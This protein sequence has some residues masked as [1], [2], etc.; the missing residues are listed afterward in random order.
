MMALNANQDT[1]ALYT[2]PIRG[3]NVIV[4]NIVE[5]NVMNFLETGITN[6]DGLAWCGNDSIALT[7][8]KNLFL[9]GPEETRKIEFPAA[10]DGIFLVTEVD[11]LR[12][13]TPSDT[14]FMDI[15]DK[16]LL[17]TF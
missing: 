4:F 7:F 1:L 13:V 11:G 5:E 16:K 14:H 9:C 12:I 17:D 2:D 3:G 8:G 6:A 10:T 15:V